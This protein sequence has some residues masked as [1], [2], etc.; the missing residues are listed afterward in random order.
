MLQTSSALENLF[1]ALAR[2]SVTDALAFS[3]TYPDHGARQLL[4]ERLV[5]SVLE[6]HG[7]GQVA[8]RSASRAKELVSLPLTGVEEK[9][10]NDYL[11][12]GEGRKSRSAKAVV[13]MRQVVTGRQKE[14]GA[15]VGVR[16]GR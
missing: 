5:A 3:R 14:L 9:W 12:T 7:S 6:E 2:T 1:A 4:F 15:V 16:A 13:Q 8:G 10:L 11:S